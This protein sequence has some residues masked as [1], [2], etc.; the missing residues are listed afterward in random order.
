MTCHYQVSK[1][2]KARLAHRLPSA[3]RFSEQPLRSW[4]DADRQA[5]LLWSRKYFSVT[6]H[7]LATLS[8]S[9]L[10]IPTPEQYSRDNYHHWTGGRGRKNWQRTLTISLLILSSSRTS[11]NIFRLV[12]RSFT[13]SSRFKYDTILNNNSKGNAPILGG[14][15]LLIR[16]RYRFLLKLKT[17][18]HL[19]GP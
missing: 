12:C 10:P 1:R 2:N 7:R 18:L 16:S 19:P 5:W 14:I 4:S 8:F 15:V 11:P 6:P 9:L 17:Q 3:E 13:N